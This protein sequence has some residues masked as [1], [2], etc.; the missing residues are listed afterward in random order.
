[1]ADIKQELAGAL[2]GLGAT[3]TEAMD[4]IEGFVPCGHP[5]AVITDA[6]TSL[7]ES[8]VAEELGEKVETVKGFIQHVSAN[9]GVTAHESADVS[10]LSE[11]KAKLL[12]ELQDVAARV[13]AA[14]TQLPEVNE[15]LYRGLAA[16]KA[17]GDEAAQAA[18]AKLAE[19]KARL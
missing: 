16:I 3:I 7:K 13:K 2:A 11:A 6:L 1:M 4:Q 9:R 10:A 14:G 12:D 15:A 19:L 18:L 5:A 8:D 17:E